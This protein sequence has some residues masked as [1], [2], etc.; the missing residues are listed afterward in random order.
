MWEGLYPLLRFAPFP[1][2]SSAAF[3]FF[4]SCLIRTEKR[5]SGLLDT[6]YRDINGEHFLSDRPLSRWRSVRLI[7]GW[8]IIRCAH[9]RSSCRGSPLRT[10][11]DG[12]SRV[13][14]PRLEDHSR[15]PAPRFLAPFVPVVSRSARPVYQGGR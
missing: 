14:Q 3:S 4:L 15:P 6:S 5:G 10:G 2:D 7:L 12:K 8:V 9:L 1:L 11:P 13:R